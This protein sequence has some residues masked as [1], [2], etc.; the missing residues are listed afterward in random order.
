MKYGFGKNTLAALAR[1][2]RKL[3]LFQTR[4]GMHAFRRGQISDLGLRPFRQGEAL[5]LHL[6]VECRS[7]RAARRSLSKIGGL[8][9]KRAPPNHST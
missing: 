4:D 3:K 8:L 6:Y 1:F 7:V 2:L 9:V 5:R